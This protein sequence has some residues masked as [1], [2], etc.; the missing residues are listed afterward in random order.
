MTALPIAFRTN[1]SKYAFAGE[2][3]L[4]N[5]YAEKQGT[6]A[7]DPLAVLPSY[8]LTL[9]CAVTDTPQR[10][11]IYLDDLDCIYSIHGTSVYKVLQSG[12]ATS[13]GIV[14]GNDIVQ[15]SRNQALIPQISIHCAAGEFYI[16]NDVVKQV[17]DPDLPS[18]VVSQDHLGGH[19][20]Y[21][22]G[23]RRFFLSS[24]NACQNIDGLDFATAEQ[25]PDP[26]LR[27]KVDGD[28]FFFK[29]KQIEQ[30][31]NTG[32]ADFPL[33]PIGAPIKHGLLATLAA[34]QFDNTLVF[35]GDD[36]VVYRIAGTG[37]VQRISDHSVERAIA[38]DPNQSAIM[39]SSHTVEGHAF[40]VFSGSNWTR[41]YDAASQVWHSRES[42]DQ[43]GRWR[44]MFPVRAW[45]KTIVGDSLTGNLYFPD[46]NSF[47]EDDQPL[48]WGMDTP[49]FHVFPNGAIMDA[50]HID[51]ATGN[52]ST[53]GQGSAP[54]LML[55][56]STNGGASWKGN[57]QLSLG[58]YG[59]R[60]RVTT[61]RLGRF[62]PKGVTFRFR[63]SDPVIRALIALDL[64][65]R[66]LKR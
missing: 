42:Y 41:I 66:P 55:D 33:E 9:Q 51:M 1:V 32:N 49:P 10:G 22:I 54:T 13:I 40:A 19:T 12:V 2:A 43:G 53:T 58:G 63:I 57:R 18:G 36:G 28:A 26:L 8:G 29:R 37:A 17:T 45:G 24:L 11:S 56:W 47:V 16:E 31:R 5:A 14:P 39:A 20:I 38:N 35:V 27:V 25:S 50:L 59:Q 62:G 23:N 30:W 3:Q 52:A 44:T 64:Q 21:A 4:I 7:K 60:V 6:D 65:V 61:R 15:M 34:T 48:V 46:K